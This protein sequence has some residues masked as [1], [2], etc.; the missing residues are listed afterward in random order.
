MTVVVKA[1]WSLTN[2]TRISPTEERCR[3][4]DLKAKKDVDNR[5]NELS[6]RLEEFYATHAGIRELLAA[7]GEI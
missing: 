6:K 5:W 4:L 2:R 1:G 3:E 7:N